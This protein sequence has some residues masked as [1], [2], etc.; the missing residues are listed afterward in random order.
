MVGFLSV[1]W[2]GHVLHKKVWDLRQL[3]LMLKLIISFLCT[4]DK[5]FWCLIYKTLLDQNSCLHFRVE[6]TE[7]QNALRFAHSHSWGDTDLGFVYNTNPRLSTL[8]WEGL[9]GIHSPFRV[10]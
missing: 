6:D 3:R 4:V 5:S 8:T 1:M 10:S 7:A 9:C 2:E